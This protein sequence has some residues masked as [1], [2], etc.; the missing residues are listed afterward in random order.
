VRLEEPCA[1][2]L[3]VHFQDVAGETRRPEVACWEAI[4]FILQIRVWNKGRGSLGNGALSCWC[5]I[6][7]DRKPDARVDA[8]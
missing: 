7:S 3:L 4:F 6:R 5:S 1:F 8:G 2:V